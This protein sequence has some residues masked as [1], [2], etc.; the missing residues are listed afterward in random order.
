MSMKK[1]KIVLEQTM[2]VSFM[3][4][5]YVSVYGALVLRKYD[6]SFDWYIPGSIVLASFVCSLLTVFILYG[7][8]G[9]NVSSARIIIRT[10]VH[11]ILI[12]AVIM[13][14]GWLFNWY[15]GVFGFILTSI[16]CAVIY[17]GAW[18]GTL[19]IF[20][21]EEKL[22]SDALDSIRDEE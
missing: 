16:I 21:H 2:M 1:M 22:I 3:V 5:C 20:K 13:A 8:S 14:F 10:V 19:L 4:L 9:K 11:F 12:Y 18:F 7:E 6:Y 15:H 17:A